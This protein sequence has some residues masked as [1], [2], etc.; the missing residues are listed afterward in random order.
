MDQIRSVIKSFG[1]PGTLLSKA[2][3][4]EGRNKT[5]QT[6]SN[7][8]SFPDTL[9]LE[10][11]TQMNMLDSMLFGERNAKLKRNIL[12]VLASWGMGK[13]AFVDEYCQRRIRAF[14]EGQSSLFPV[15]ITFNSN[16][17]G[18]HVK[19]D[20]DYG[21]EVGTDLAA[22]LL[23]SYF[24]SNPSEEMLQSI[25]GAL[26]NLG[27]VILESTS[28]IECITEDLREQY[29]VQ[30]PKILIACDDL[31]KSLNAA[32]VVAHL[33]T[34]LF[35]DDEVECFFTAAT[36][37]PFVREYDR[38]KMIVPLSLLSF[39]ASVKLVQSFVA[40]HDDDSSY[41]LKAASKLARLSGGH[42]RTIQAF[43]GVVSRAHD[44]DSSALVQWNDLV[45]EAVA[46]SAVR[47]MSR[48]HLTEAQILL[49]M[50]KKRPSNDIEFNEVVRGAVESGALC[51]NTCDTYDFD[52]VE[53]F[54][55]PLL[56]RSSLLNLAAQSNSSPLIANLVELLDLVGLRDLKVFWNLNAREN[57]RMDFE[58][59]N[60]Y[61]DLLRRA[62]VCSSLGNLRTDCNLLYNLHGRYPSYYQEDCSN[63]NFN[64]DAQYEVLNIPCEYG[65]PSDNSADAA[66]VAL[67][68]TMLLDPIAR[69]KVIR[70]R[71]SKRGEAGYGHF[72][73]LD[74]D[75]RRRPLI[76]LVET[77]LF[78]D[79]QSGNDDTAFIGQIV[80][81]LRL[82]ESLAWSKLGV[83]VEDVVHTFIADRD[84]VRSIDWKS[85]LAAAG[86]SHRK[87]LI[88]DMGDM[89]SL[90][91]LMAS[92]LSSCGFDDQPV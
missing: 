82:S 48:A 39:D 65:F 14:E 88:S 68:K 80:E 30:E 81:K 28:V 85:E 29:G 38:F 84:K 9:F 55:S 46:D 63:L 51:F 47:E 16:A 69:N 75:G 61:L 35:N 15:A 13:S 33:C 56:L 72:F 77:I 21:Y 4:K 26:H 59:F 62:Y 2:V 79:K 1:Q 23:M 70:V 66:S 12:V 50:Q 8:R 57:K 18:K 3:L 6:V 53:L 22:R 71:P 83:L 40:G 41:S 43:E 10:R 36:L 11:E 17:I 60:L 89:R 90:H 52:D 87:V 45:F 25:Y 58:D 44:L 49:M 24:L 64:L 27:F 7:H 91:G 34:V 86:L 31:E 74:Y 20:R 54:T 67:V 92:I 32:R 37:N 73:I 19:N 5:V 78:P 42:P 76:Q